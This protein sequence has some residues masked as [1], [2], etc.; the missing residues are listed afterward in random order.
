MPTYSL[1][2]L[3]NKSGE[4][5]EAAFRGP[6]DITS[7]G[8]RKFVLLTAEDY[9]RIKGRSAHRVVHVDDLSPDEAN[10]YIA[11]LS[12]PIDEVND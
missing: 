2:D 1:T 4:V 9:D 8:K 7:R 3:S 12:A 6:V 11:A 5:T 10:H